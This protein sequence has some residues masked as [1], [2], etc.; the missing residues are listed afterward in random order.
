VIAEIGR[1][2]GCERTVTFDRTAAVSSVM[3]LLE[4]GEA[5]PV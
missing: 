1:A 4:S 2:A 5:T 3:R